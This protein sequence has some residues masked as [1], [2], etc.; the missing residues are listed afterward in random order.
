MAVARQKE[1]K[2]SMTVVATTTFTVAERCSDGTKGS[3]GSPINGDSQLNL[4]GRLKSVPRL[5]ADIW[6]GRLKSVPRLP[7]DIWRLHI[8]IREADSEARAGGIGATRRVG[9]PLRNLRRKRPQIM[10][11]RR[12]TFWQ[13]VILALLLAFVS[14][15]IHE[16]GHW[17]FYETLGLGP[18][19]GFTSLVQIWGDPPLHP[20]E[21]VTTIAPN[22]DKGWLRLR[23]SPSKAEEIVAL[24]AGP[25][26]SLLGVIFGLSLLR[27]NRNSAAKQMGLVLALLVS[28]LLGQY[29]LRGFSRMGGDEFF[30]AADL[31]IPK[32]TIDIPFALAYII[33]FALGVWL[34]GDWRTRL[35]WLGAI[36][37]GS[38]PA[39]FFQIKA[40][41]LIQA[42]VDQGNPLFRPLLGWSLPVVV[43]NAM[44]LCAF[45]MWWR[46][47]SKTSD[48]HS[49]IGM[50]AAA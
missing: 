2:D 22:G 15:T 23:S 48:E 5:P 42:Q 17:V 1:M 38:V 35:K 4:Q 19:W 21:W 25:L 47:A 20:N 44:V 9:I 46:R 36:M 28:L 49:R 8:S 7:A 24:F 37:L 14:Q 3:P 13:L 32:Y 40:N 34:L 30:L 16:S 12:I 26:A 39:G 43:V 6:Q 11:Y 27:F 18:V 45:W 50:L 29:Y 31:G 33:T 41:I 10:D